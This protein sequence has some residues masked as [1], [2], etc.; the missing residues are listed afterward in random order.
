MKKTVHFLAGVLVLVL[1][2]E[3]CSNT[4]TQPEGTAQTLNTGGISFKIDK[5]NA[6]EDV[7][8]VEAVMVS[9]AG[10][11][12]TADMDLASD[13]AAQFTFTDISV[14]N[15]Q[16]TVNAYNAAD[17]LLYTGSAELEILAGVLTQISLVLNPT[18]METGSVQI[19]VTWGTATADKTLIL[20]PG[21]EGKN[22]YID[23]FES[24]KNFS[25]DPYLIL[26]SGPLWTSSDFHRNRIFM[27]FNLSSVPQTAVVKEAYLYLY[28]DYVPNPEPHY[29]VNQGPAIITV[30]RI[31]QR[32]DK[33]GVKWSNQP[34]Y[35]DLNQVKYTTLGT[36]AEDL[37]IDVTALTQDYV[38]KP[39]SSFGYR[40]IL[41][42]DNGGLLK[43]ASCNH[44]DSLV[45]PKLEI[46][47][48]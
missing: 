26:Y 2:L 10:D 38:N 3:G 35:T 21:S 48:K 25:S 36:P 33:T 32:W 34:K 27:D 42:D 11:T 20:Q 1:L 7:V 17:K 5:A 6:P 47:Y 19:N 14:G 31:T 29:D 44:P 28:H 9:E 4:S 12:L 43:F 16:L 18:G 15:W 8:K 24:N 46:I 22:A 13:N 37:K 39:D 23:Q 41:L 30:K 40:V 45:R